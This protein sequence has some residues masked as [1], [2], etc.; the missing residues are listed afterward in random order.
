MICK[1]NWLFSSFT[2]LPSFIYCLVLVLLDLCNWQVNAIWRFS[3]SFDSRF[4]FQSVKKV[5]K[6]RTFCEIICVKRN[7]G[8]FNKDVVLH[9]FLQSKKVC[10]FDFTFICMICRWGGGLGD[11]FLGDKFLGGNFHRGEFS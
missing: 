7:L 3:L 8:Y 11:N 5:F 4:L 2:S 1:H 10:I 9:S 6:P